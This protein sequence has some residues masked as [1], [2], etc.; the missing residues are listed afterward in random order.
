MNRLMP[1]FAFVFC[2]LI[3][4]AL[5]AQTIYPDYQDG[6]LYLKISNKSAIELLENSPANTIADLAA[7][8][9]IF[10]N[11]GVSNLHKP[12]YLL[13]T[14]IFDRTYQLEFANPAEVDNLIEALMSLDFIEYAEKIP[15]NKPVFTP[16][17]PQLS[18]QWHLTKINAAGAWDIH[19]GG[20][21]LVAIVDDACKITHQDLAPNIYTNPNEI[22]GNGIDDDNNGYI[23]DVNGFDVAD[24]D[25]NPNPPASAS[26]SSFS[27]GTHCSGIAS[28]ATNNGLGIA[29]IGFS[30]KILPVKCTGDNGDPQYIEEGYLGIQYA[31]AAGADVISMSWGGGGFST[32]EQNIFNQAHNQGI[33]LV[34]AAGNS[35]VN[36]AF[37][38]AAY[39][40]VI[41]VASSAETDA[42]SSFSNYGTWVD[43]TAP[44]SNILSTVAGSNSSYTNYSGTSMACPLVAGL[45]GL[46]KSYQTNLTPDEI[47]SCITA[48]AD[49][50][51]AQNSSY[52]GQLGAGRINAQ[53]ALT[54][55]NPNAPPI[56]Q[57]TSDAN[58]AM[59]PGTMVQFTDL[60]TNNPTAWSWSFPGGTPSSST[61]QNPSVTYNTD[62]VYQV[63]LTATNQFG[64]NTNTYTN[65]INI[66]VVNGRYIFYEN[67]FES[68]F[69]GWVVSNPDAGITWQTISVGGTQSGS[70]AVYVNCYNYNSQGQIDEMVSPILDFSGKN[71]VSLSFDYAHRRYS[72]DYSDQLSVFLSTDGGATYPITLFQGAENGTGNF[73]TGYLITT[74]FIPTS[75]QDWCY[76]AVTSVTCPEIDLSAY[77]NLS[78]IK[79]KFQ[80]LNDYGNNIFVDNVRLSSTC[81]LPAGTIQASIQADTQAGCAP[82]TVSFSDASAANPAVS[83][84]LWSFPG[85]T[86]SSSTLANPTVVYNEA[87]SYAVTL[88]VSNGNNDQITLNN[89]INALSEYALD[90]TTYCSSGGQ[91][92]SEEWIENFTFGGINNSSGNDGGYGDFGDIS[93]TVSL[94]QTIPFS[95]TPNFFNGT[96]SEYFKIY[97]D[98]NGDGDFADA[99]ELAF[100]AGGTTSSTMSGNITIPATATVGAARMRVSMKYVNP[101]SG[102]PS[103]TVSQGPCESFLYGEVED[104]TLFINAGNTCLSNYQETTDYTAGSGIISINSSNWISADNTVASG[105]DVSYFAADYID[106]T[107]NFQAVSGC[108]FAAIIQDCVSNKSANTEG[109]YELLSALTQGMYKE[110]PLFSVLPNPARD[111]IVV[112]NFAASDALLRMLSADGRVVLQQT[113]AG[114]SSQNIDMS[115]YC[116]GVYLIQFYTPQTSTWITQKLIISR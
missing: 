108:D 50:I 70:Q 37:Y 24:N 85:G 48:S 41:S 32:T 49:N 7:I 46:M 100:D 64:S 103:N 96:F 98:Y 110:E 44:G 72:A 74:N 3:S 114:T 106:L 93:E 63:S 16:N 86:P 104:Y 73:A 52:I 90:C 53:A 39:N 25:N 68:G 38:P 81:T 30:N 94:E 15:L 83:S 40:Y 17:D 95:I 65:Y 45:C 61:Q 51:D 99:N 21:A 42:K 75:E 4:F 22:A 1:I 14:P 55:V 67:G 66:D 60:S 101:S 111:K 18:S 28:G 2:M 77:D 54:C 87:G 10:K 113:I 23:D 112:E 12:F 76:A 20:N 107:E 29:S 79:I 13:R 102:T 59:C 71:N 47:E 19:Q 5:S 82:L 33:T 62:G 109:G 35:N 11:F 43:I 92:S 80:V 88:S 34:A 6:K 27:H 105:A 115:T 78:N 9:D 116:N 56:V 26:N 8:E 57:F 31:I 58:E 91:N 69:G 84:W 36:T 89:Y 97:I